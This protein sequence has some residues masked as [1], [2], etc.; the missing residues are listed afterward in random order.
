MYRMRE[1]IAID[2]PLSE[3]ISRM[4]IVHTFQSIVWVIET[5]N[6]PTLNK[7]KL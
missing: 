2:G 1:K 4:H 3:M 6:L 7:K 5:L